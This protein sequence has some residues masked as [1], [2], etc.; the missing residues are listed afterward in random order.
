[1]PP[2]GREITNNQ[3]F[4]Y[5]CQKNLKFSPIFSGKNVPTLS[6]RAGS[7]SSAFQALPLPANKFPSG[8]K[9]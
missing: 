7:R 6:L 2:Q 9:Y 4:H 3:D 8:R 1:M 5:L